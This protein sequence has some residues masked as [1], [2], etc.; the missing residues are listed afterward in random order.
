CCI[1]VMLFFHRGKK[2]FAALEV[3]Y[4]VIEGAACSCKAVAAACIAPSTPALEMRDTVG[5]PWPDGTAAV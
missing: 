1:A 4:A 5:C 2:A 3:E